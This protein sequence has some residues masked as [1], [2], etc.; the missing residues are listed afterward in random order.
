MVPGEYRVYSVGMKNPSPRSASPVS[1]TYF[2][3]T[4]A[5]SSSYSWWLLVVMTSV[6]SFLSRCGWADDDALKI[7]ANKCARC[8]GENGQ[9]VADGYEKPLAGRTS[10]DELVELIVT[11]MPEED[12]EQCAGEEARKVAEFIYEKFY[13]PSK[14]STAGF[15]LTR[16]TVPQYRN[17]VAD[18]LATFAPTEAY[19][20]PDPRRRPTQRPPSPLLENVSAQNSVPGLLAMYYQSEGMSKANNLV[21]R[22]VD[23]RIDFNFGEDSPGPGISADQFSIIWE[24][25]LTANA[26]GDYEFRLTT[27]NGARMYFNLDPQAALR[28]LRDDSSASGQSALLDAWVGSGKKRERSARVFLLGGRTYPLR[29]ESFKYKEHTASVK[30]EWKPPHGTWSVLDFNHT[31]TAASPRVFVCE[32]PFPADDRSLGY[33]RG[34]SISP[35]WQAAVTNAAIE[36][37]AEVVDRLPGLAGL[38]E[39]MKNREQTVQTFLSKFAER[40]FRR[41]LIRRETKSLMRAAF[42]GAPSLETAARRGVVMTLMS[43]HFLYTDLTPA[44]QAP[45]P[46]VI[47]TQLALAMWDSIPDQTLLDA[48]AD[49][50][51]LTPQH[52]ESQARRMLSDPRTHSK[53]RKFFDSWLELE[54]RDL[55]KDREKF[56]EFDEAVVADLRRSL[57][58]FIEQV[59][60]SPQSDY[61]ELLLADYLLLNDRLA[62]LYAGSSGSGIAGLGITSSDA[63]EWSDASKRSEAE[64]QVR[65]EIGVASAVTPHARSQ[66][67]RVSFPSGLRSGVLT[68]PYLLSAFAYHNNTSPIHRGVFLTRNIVGR[69]LNPPP[70]AIAF[71]DSEFAADLTMR[72]KITQLTRDTACM[73]CHSVINPLGFALESYD[74]VGRWRDSENDKPID[75]SSEY[76]TLAGEKLNIAS[77]HD[78]AMVAVSSGAAHKAFV[79]QVFEQVVKQNPLNFGENVI[80]QLTA[81]FI[82][83][84]FNIR[85]LW[86]RVAAQAV[87]SFANSSTDSDLNHSQL[88]STPR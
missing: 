28:K 11:T 16:L 64:G 69:Q 22:R 58:L 82:A 6:V 38:T 73:S 19:E 15:E 60:W 68:H 34:S 61:R 67:R 45:A 20:E 76:T 27:E 35:E 41:P 30:F 72:E 40:A 44:D 3:P 79:T 77:A 63:S 56:P 39:E 42:D 49:E 55:G 66:F 24:G 17:A 26:T 86:A 70:M 81:E 36:T 14:A 37:A 57:E 48:A 5:F 25:S 18:V 50:M 84:E 59:V 62:K 43:P 53:V 54:E 10:L 78:V 83:D 31:T 9:G 74:A 1:P 12:P 4:T 21:I 85:N 87:I 75:T 33:E 2:S 47:A 32:T 23:P 51:L 80:D 52:I 7:Y 88:S 65:S 8:H 46:H 29:V 71:K 13:V